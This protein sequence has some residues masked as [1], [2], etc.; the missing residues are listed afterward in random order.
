MSGLGAGREGDGGGAA[1]DRRAREGK[2]DTWRRTIANPIRSR[3]P[4]K[5]VAV[6][7]EHLAEGVG[8]VGSMRRAE[9]GQGDILLG[10]ADADVACRRFCRMGRGFCVLATTRSDRRHLIERSVVSDF[11]RRRSSSPSSSVL[12]Q[13]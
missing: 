10:I 13:R 12:H 5:M 7:V 8:G 3:E 9:R 11:F 2:A 4:G 1:L 6:W